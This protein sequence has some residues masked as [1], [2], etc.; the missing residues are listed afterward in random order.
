MAAGGELACL[1]N[2]LVLSFIDF[3]N[4][5]CATIPQLPALTLHTTCAS[6]QLGARRRHSFIKNL[7]TGAGA[8][9]AF[10]IT[11]S[12]AQ[13]AIADFLG[14]L[15]HDLGFACKKW[16]INRSNTEVAGI[17]SGMGINTTIYFC[18]WHVLDKIM[19]QVKVKLLV[20]EFSNVHLLLL[21]LLSLDQA[22][23]QQGCCKQDATQWRACR[24]Q[25]NHICTHTGRL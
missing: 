16:M 8:P 10:M 20:R 9:A 7:H 3:D 25:E 13:Y 2:A 5:F 17:Q 12:E 23:K 15:C 11:G 19:A 14:W 21:H 22:Q 4:S 6:W 24:L 1:S 18:L